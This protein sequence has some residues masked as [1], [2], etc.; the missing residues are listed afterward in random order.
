MA[1]DTAAKR[2]SVS[3][4]LTGLAIVGVTMDATPDV[5]W[6]QSAGWG[7]Q[8]IEVVS[9]T[10]APTL[11]GPADVYQIGLPAADVYGIPATLADVYGI[12]L[13]AADVYGDN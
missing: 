11:I 8:G 5:A 7:Y 13:P 10:F 2:R 9:S 1:I 12:P 4:I 3:G 6:R